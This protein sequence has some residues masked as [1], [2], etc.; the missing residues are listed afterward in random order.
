[1]KFTLA[2][3]GENGYGMLLNVVPMSLTMLRLRKTVSAAMKPPGVI[4]TFS[5]YR[6]CLHHDWRLRIA[7]R[8]LR[9]IHGLSGFDLLV[10]FLVCAISSLS[11][12]ICFSSRSVWR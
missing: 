6:R 12:L 2:E 9:G 5:Q 10:F 11:A 8:R 3:E 1:M 4:L 7:G